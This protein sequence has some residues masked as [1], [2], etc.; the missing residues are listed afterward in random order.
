[1]TKIT[2]ETIYPY[3]TF[4]MDSTTGM[5]AVPEGMFWRVKR[6]LFGE[7]WE[8]QLRKHGMFWSFKVES[9]TFDKSEPIIRETILRG[10]ASAY[11]DYREKQAAY[12]RAKVEPVGKALF[13]DYPPKSLT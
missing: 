3:G 9:R 7:F 13:G 10:A 2:R 6:I 12:K 4:Y 11:E 1:M 8:V 5:P